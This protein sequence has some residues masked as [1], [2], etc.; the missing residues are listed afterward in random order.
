MDLIT[1]FIAEAHVVLRQG[2]KRFLVQQ[3]DM[4]VVGEAM[5]GRQVLRR[6]EALQPDLLLLDL[7]MPKLDGLAVLPRICAKSPRTRILLLADFFEEEF[8]AR[9]LQVGVHGCVL[10]TA[11]PTELVKAIRATHAGELWAPRKL[12][13]QVVE[14]L[15]Q[16]MDEWEG[17][18]SK[19]WGT[20]TDREQEVIIWAA[21]GMTNQE[22]ATELGISAK[23]VKTHLQNVF[24]KLNVRRRVHLPRF[25]LTSLPPPAVLPPSALRRE[26]RA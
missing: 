12:L 16:R 5:D 17:S 9:A 22:I 10:K 24:R 13:T 21:Q 15:R 4:Q 3:Q 23:T 2:L 6:V 7:R 19:M 14:N 20:L 11:L 26:G 18:L 8:I 25:R 1:V